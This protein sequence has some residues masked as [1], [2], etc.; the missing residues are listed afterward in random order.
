MNAVDTAG[1]TRLYKEDFDGSL[2]A[3]GVEVINPFAAP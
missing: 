1:V 3:E 2:R